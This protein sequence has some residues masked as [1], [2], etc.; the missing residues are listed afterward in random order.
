MILK[1]YQRKTLDTVKDFLMELHR[2]REKME[3]IREM[4]AEMAGAVDWVKPAFDQVAPG[5][6][7]IARKNGI[8]EELPNFCLKIPTGGGKT[9]LATRVILKRAVEGVSGR[10]QRTVG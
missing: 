1:D 5:R 8:G 9:L 3:R 7:T 10:S 6:Y 2:R 4:D